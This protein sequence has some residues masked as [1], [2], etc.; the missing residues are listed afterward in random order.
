MAEENSFKENLNWKKLSIDAVNTIIATAIGIIL[1]LLVDKWR[2][3]VNNQENYQKVIV[4]TIVNLEN[5]KSQIENL[6]SYVDYSSEEFDTY[7]D[8]EYEE[9]DSTMDEIGYVFFSENFQQQDRW[10]EENFITNGGFIEDA[11]LRLK[12]GNVYS[13]IDLCKNSFAHLKTVSDKAYDKYVDIYVNEDSK[14]AFDK[15]LTDK[16]FMAYS[17]AITETKY[18]VDTWLKSIDELTQEIVKIANA[19][20]KQLNDMRQSSK[21]ILDMISKSREE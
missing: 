21:K 11:D 14:N 3:N 12:I 9:T 19:D 10:I 13:L 17:S 2:E 4:A 18:N 15:L 20:E 16:E 8:A 6:E 1:G 7:Y 5:Y